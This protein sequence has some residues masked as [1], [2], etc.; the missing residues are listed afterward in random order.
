MRKQRRGKGG[1]KESAEHEKEK[2]EASREEDGSGNQG[3]EEG[4]EKGQ[5]LTGWKNKEKRERE[6]V[7]PKAE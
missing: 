4:R 3:R 6:S 2:E 5:T 1:Q 7:P